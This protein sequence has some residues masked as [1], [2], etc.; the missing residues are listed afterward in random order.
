MPSNDGEAAVGGRL[1]S[2][3][4]PVRITVCLTVLPATPFVAAVPAAGI[5]GLR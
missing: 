2:G 4:R 5:A 3:D 1:P